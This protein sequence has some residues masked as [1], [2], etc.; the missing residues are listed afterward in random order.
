MT[1]KECKALLEQNTQLMWDELA[2]GSHAT[3]RRLLDLCLHRSVVKD[4]IIEEL[5]KELE[6]RRNW[7]TRPFQEK[8][9]DVA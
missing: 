6:E 9:K 3:M 1:L 5:E 2:N 8:K 7:E 4:M